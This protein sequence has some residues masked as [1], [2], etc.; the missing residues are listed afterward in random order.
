MKTKCMNSCKSILI[1]SGYIEN[2]RKTKFC[3]DSTKLYN[4]LS[5]IKTHFLL[6]LLNWFGALNLQ[7][8]SAFMSHYKIPHK[9]CFSNY[10]FLT[11]GKICKANINKC[12]R[13]N[14]A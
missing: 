11:C 4:F 9:K 3:F 13:H 10:D 7:F 6:L 8:T 1:N 5:C 2:D 14:E 12:K